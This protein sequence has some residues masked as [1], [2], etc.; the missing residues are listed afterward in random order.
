MSSCFDWGTTRG[1]RWCHPTLDT[2]SSTLNDSLL[3]NERRPSCNFRRSVNCRY[4]PLFGS[5]SYT[6]V[7]IDVVGV[8]LPISKRTEICP[9]SDKAGSTD[10]AGINQVSCVLRHIFLDAFLESRQRSKTTTLTSPSL[11]SP[12]FSHR[13]R[14]KRSYQQHQ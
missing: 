13:F 11:L 1:Y 5:R 10:V 4:V 9:R 8:N 12:L 7:W 3:R 6:S 14:S 2:W